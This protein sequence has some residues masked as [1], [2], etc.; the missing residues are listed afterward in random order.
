MLEKITEENLQEILN[1]IVLSGSSI[2]VHG[3]DKGD[4]YE[5]ANSILITGLKNSKHHE[6][7]TGTIEFLVDKDKHPIK[8]TIIFDI[9][10]TKVG[11]NSI[12][13]LMIKDYSY[14]YEH[15][16]KTVYQAFIVQNMNDY[17][18][19]ETLKKNNA[20]EYKK[21]KNDIANELMNHLINKYPSLEGKISII[22]VWTPLTYNEYYHSYYGSYMGF[23]ITN[24]CNC[25]NITN[26]IKG[27]K[28][29]YLATC[30]QKIC[31]G[32]PVGLKQGIDIVNQIVMSV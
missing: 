3:I 20:E 1:N 18:Y 24:K 17:T 25:F 11:N 22:D 23:A 16:P 32:L 4:F 27:I 7:L 21:I 15:K 26:K 5:V 8:D 2:G 14:L 19:W 29:F 12:N 28:N 10:S 13:R 6:G 31:G 9:P 30:W